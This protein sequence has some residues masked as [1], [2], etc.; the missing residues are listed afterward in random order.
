MS[1][2]T[3]SR[4]VILG[5]TSGIGAPSGSGDRYI[6]EERI[7]GYRPESSAAILKSNPRYSH[8]VLPPKASGIMFG[9]P[10]SE[11]EMP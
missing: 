2:S 9:V 10:K 11:G 6:T 1:I 5:G 8:G 7:M 3:A 4:V